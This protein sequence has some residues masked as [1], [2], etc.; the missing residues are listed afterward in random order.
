MAEAKYMIDYTDK[1]ETVETIDI[2]R[3]APL[4]M[5]DVLLAE[6]RGFKRGIE[7]QQALTARLAE[8]SARGDGYQEI[9]VEG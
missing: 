7:Y 6:E 4:A 3:R 2:L 9:G 5:K 8:K 1:D